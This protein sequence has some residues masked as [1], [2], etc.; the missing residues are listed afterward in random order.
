MVGI[1]DGSF[2]FG[3]GDGA[4]LVQIGCLEAL[5]QVAGDELP[6]LWADAASIE[7]LSRL[8]ERAEV[9]AHFLEGDVAVAVDVQHLE[10]ECN[11]FRLGAVHEQAESA[12]K[13]LK[14]D[15]STLVGIKGIEEL[16]EPLLAR[17]RVWQLH[18]TR[19]RC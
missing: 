6:L 18:R 13:L 17:R 16:L 4:T 8:E 11:F 10:G 2:E 3:E 14:I 9:I 19:G 1:L 7:C 5:L 12:R 15:R